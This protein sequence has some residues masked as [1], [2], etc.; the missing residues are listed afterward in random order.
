M[1]STEE[2]LR[3][4]LARQGRARKGPILSAISGIYAGIA[5]R[6]PNCHPDPMN[7]LLRFNNTVRRDP[8]IEDWFFQFADPL[9]LMV[10]PGFERMRG[11]GPDVR[12]LLHDGCPVVCV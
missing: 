10:R 4:L 11:C 2:K 1:G 7:E 12:E 5:R 6:E 8:R 3:V 9:R